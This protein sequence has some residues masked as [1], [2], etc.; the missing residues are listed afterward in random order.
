MPPCAS[1]WPLVLGIAGGEACQR[2]ATSLLHGRAAGVPA[3]CLENQR[4]AALRADLA[5]VLGIVQGEVCQRQ[6]TPLLHVRSVGVPAHWREHGIDA[7][8]V[9]GIAGGPSA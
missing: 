2:H 4:D 9:I 1:I 6:A 8:N 3:H 7:H 5:L